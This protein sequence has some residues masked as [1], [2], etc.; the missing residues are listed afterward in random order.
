MFFFYKTYE[1][2]WSLK[3]AFCEDIFIINKFIYLFNKKKILMPKKILK[4]FYDSWMVIS[5]WY[6][7][8]E[9]VS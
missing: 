2:L 3:A 7:V 6:S 8:V 4:N 5:F 1:Y 9:A